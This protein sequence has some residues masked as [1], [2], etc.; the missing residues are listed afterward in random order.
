D[1]RIAY[2][3]GDGSNFLSLWDA[4]TLAQIRTF[5]LG[6]ANQDFITAI[7]FNNPG[8]QVLVY[9]ESHSRGQVTARRLALWDVATGGEIR[10][11]QI[12][13]SESWE[14]YSLAFSPDGQ[15]ALSG[16][17]F[18]R[19]YAVSLWEVATGREIRRF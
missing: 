13:Q 19:V 15:Y 14:I 18:G 4:A 5:Q 7:A 2:T 12:T 8:N 11:F 10:E 9:S 16:G 17:R 3:G 1:G 6:N